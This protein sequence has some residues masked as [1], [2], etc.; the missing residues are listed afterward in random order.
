MLPT[1][2]IENVNELVPGVSNVATAGRGGQKLVFRGDID[3]TTYA[4]KFA[5]LTNDNGED[6]D[7]ASAVAIRAARE[8]AIMRECDSDHMVKLGP[9]DL[10]VTEVANQKIIYF[11]EEFIDGQDLHS[12]ITTDGPMSTADVCRLGIEI[13]DAISALWGLDMVHRDI[14]PKNIMQ[15]SGCKSF[16]LLDA[17]L[18]LD[19]VGESVSD[20]FPVGTLPYC[21]PEQ[22][23]YGDR[24]TKMDFRSDMFS[25]GVT[26]Y[27]MSTGQHPFALPGE[28]SRQIYSRLLK[29]HPP[30]PST[31]NTA[32]P[33]EF[34]RI[35]RRMLGKAPHLR[36]RS[37]ERLITALTAIGA[38]Q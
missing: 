33:S 29:H 3:G 15:R 13:A 10:T 11:T 9:I 32:L 22:F 8:T 12:L 17:G 27:F 30:A 25:L 26:M 31:I 2:T 37:I 23:D 20:G 21:P 34:D 36:Y 1:I 19:R 28:D 5:L 14:K 7:L 6:D 4:I 16:V 24:R 18:A 35:I 38:G